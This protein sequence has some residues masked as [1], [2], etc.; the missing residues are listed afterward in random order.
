M[1]KVLL[2]VNLFIYLLFYKEYKKTK[3]LLITKK[4]INN[5]SNRNLGSPA[6]QPPE[7]SAVDLSISAGLS[8]SQFQRMGRIGN[9]QHKC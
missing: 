8:S 4:T 6:Y 1:L 7:S 2:Q 5:K 9:K 3:K